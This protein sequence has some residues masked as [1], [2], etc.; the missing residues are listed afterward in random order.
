MVLAVRLGC[1]C[2]LNRSYHCVV[3][4][5]YVDNICR[6]FLRSLA[7]LAPALKAGHA[8]GLTHSVPS[9]SK[10]M[11]LTSRFLVSSL[12]SVSLTLRF[13]VR[14]IQVVYQWILSSLSFKY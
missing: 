12:Y 1:D 5:K 14:V 11:F 9:N 6:P 7:S 13:P 10:L 2:Y 4:V 8:V 3:Y